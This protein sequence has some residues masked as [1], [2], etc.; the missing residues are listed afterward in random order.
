MTTRRVPLGKWRPD[1]PTLESPNLWVAKNALPRGKGYGPMQSLESLTAYGHIFSAAY[2]ALSLT[3]YSGT[4][5]NFGGSASTLEKIVGGAWANVSRLGNYALGTGGRWEM[6]VF[7]GAGAGRLP[8]VIATTPADLVQY[9]EV[10][11]SALFANLSAAAP[12]AR[13]VAVIGQHLHLGHTYDAVDGTVAN[14]YWW[15]A[16]GNATSWP[17]PGTD[18]AVSA[19][20]DKDVFVG[21]GGAITGIIG[22]SEYGVYFQERAVWRVD[23]VGGDI[24][25]SARKMEDQRGLAVPGLACAFG[26]NI[27]YFAD[28]GWY[29]FDGVESYAVGKDCVDDWFRQDFQ[30]DYRSRVSTMVDPDLPI[31]HIGY[32]GVGH[33]SGTPNRILHYNW[34]TKSFS[35]SVVE[36]EQ[37]CLVV[38]P[39]P[40]L[41]M[42]RSPSPIPDDLTSSWDDVP[43]ATR[44]AGAFDT[45]HQL[46]TFTGAALAAEFETGDFELSPGRR[47]NLGS[48]RPIVTGGTATVAVAGT[49]VRNDV[50]AYGTAVSLDASGKANTRKGARYHRLKLSIESGWTGDAI[51]LDCESRSA[52]MR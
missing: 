36:H 51:A 44:V 32:T 26:R 9:Y 3:D 37:L 31:V 34:F 49:E 39:G 50:P 1:D 6:T 41:S 8:V 23:Y 13:H 33:S 47:A 35:Y 15:S 30:F 19:Q 20:S 14:Q 22:G 18:A 25:Y 40:D 38:N 29:V 28:D 16:L 7:S 46:A 52:G 17:T 21:E 11:T 42:D 45:S 24:M 5:H 48:V 2:G 4:T 27:L 10:G 12:Q 43:T